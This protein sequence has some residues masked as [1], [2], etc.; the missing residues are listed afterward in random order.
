MDDLF[1]FSKKLGFWVFLVNPTVVLVLLSAS[2]ERY[3]VS[4]MW[5]FFLGTE[6]YFHIFR[7][8]LKLSM[9]SYT[10]GLNKPFCSFA[11]YSKV[12]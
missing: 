8:K 11:V 1:R 10:F 6:N 9:V 4:R 12:C 3:F 5:D 2:V 7:I